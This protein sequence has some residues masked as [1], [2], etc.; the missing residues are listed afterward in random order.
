MQR[1]S[2]QHN[3]A[4]VT[5]GIDVSKARLDICILP[6]GV[7]LQMANNK[8]GHKAVIRELAAYDVSCIIIEPT[9]R[10]HRPLHLALEQAD[11]AVCLVNPYRSRKFADAVGQLAKSDVIDARMLALYG[12]QTSPPATSARPDLMNEI[13]ELVMARAALVRD[14]TALKNRLGA[15]GC[16]Q[17]K[18]LFKKR[19]GNIA[20]DIGRLEDIILGLIK[21]DEDLNRWYDI[22]LSIPGIGRISAMVLIATMPELGRVNSKQIA[23]LAGVAPMNWDSGTMR[24]KRKTKGGRFEARRALYMPALSVATRSPGPMKAFYESL[25][26]R[27]KPAKLALTAVM[28]KMIIQANTLI[29]ENRIWKENYP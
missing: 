17:L 18:V 21:A 15:T 24:G 23:A 26:K 29:K 19:L 12:A 16:R 2:K 25:V 3:R 22:L 11:L 7:Q 20:G 6:C 14:Q 28:R 4:K 9:G 27:G 5:V 8:K 13:N 1:K 10:L